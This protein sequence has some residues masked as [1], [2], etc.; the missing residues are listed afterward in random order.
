[1]RESSALACLWERL[2]AAAARL[3]KKSRAKKLPWID[4]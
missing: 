3:A 4:L 2:V 1:L